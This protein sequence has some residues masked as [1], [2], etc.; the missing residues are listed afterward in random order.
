MS[1]SKTLA[2]VRK[3]FEA[4]AR[5]DAEAYFGAYHPEIVISE[6]PSLPK[7]LGQPGIA[8]S[9]RIAVS[10]NPSSLPSAI[11]SSCCGVFAP[12]RRTERA[13]TCRSSASTGCK[14]GKLLNRACFLST[15]LR[16]C[17]SLA[18]R[19]PS[20]QMPDRPAR[21]GD[22]Q[23]PARITL[24]AAQPL[25][26]VQCATPCAAGASAGRKGLPCRVFWRGVSSSRMADHGVSTGPDH[27]PLGCARVGE[28]GAITRNPACSRVDG[29]RTD[30][31]KSCDRKRGEP[32]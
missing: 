15:R 24:S 31:A 27:C 32:V 1:S 3:L 14:T 21:S 28:R 10:S 26:D 22:D 25:S 30:D 12:A 8:T 5:R 18:E 6:A 23:H 4:A 29:S 19:A 11:A 2:T 9:P 16:S 7:D 13:S 17:D 20:P